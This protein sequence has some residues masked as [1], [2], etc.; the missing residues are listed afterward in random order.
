M[1]RCPDCGHVRAW[2]LGDG[3]LKCRRCGHR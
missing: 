3:R 1:R 2:R